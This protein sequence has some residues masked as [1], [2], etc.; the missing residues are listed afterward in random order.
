MNFIKVFRFI[1]CLIKTNFLILSRFLFNCRI[2]HFF[3]SFGRFLHIWSFQR[4][5]SGSNRKHLTFIQLECRILC[6]NS[7]CEWISLILFPFG[8]LRLGFID[9]KRISCYCKCFL[10]FNYW[11]IFKKVW[12]LFGLFLIFVALFL[13]LF[14]YFN[15]NSFHL[16]YLCYNLSFSI[17]LVFIIVMLLSTSLTKMKIG[18]ILHQ[19]S[20]NIRMC[21]L[22]LMFFQ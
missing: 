3:T 19:N 15:F 21:H 18:F 5:Q 9:L 11:L 6:K 17:F 10:R 4:K 8:N 16:R 13:I 7:L 14:Y 1:R 20:S 2:R 12:N 22:N